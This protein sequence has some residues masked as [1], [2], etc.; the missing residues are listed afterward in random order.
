VVHRQPALDLL[1]EDRPMTRA[2]TSLAC[3]AL[4]VVGLTAGCSGDDPEATPSSPAPT[5]VAAPPP[6]PPARACYDLDFEAAA[7]PT[8][9]ARPVSCRSPHTTV[10]IHV[11]TIRPVVDGHLLAV[12]SDTAQAQVARRCRATYA[13]HVG[14]TVEARRLSRFTVVWFTPTL[15]QSDDGAL[16]FRCDLVALAGHDRL[17]QLPGRARGVLDARDALDRFG[18]C[19]TT[20]PASKRFQR[21]ICSRRHS[22]RARAT[23]AVPR[24][25][26]YLDKHAGAVADAACHDV[27]ARLAGDILKLKWSFEWPTREQWDAGQRYGI[28]WTPDPA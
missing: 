6:A 17:A 20:S 25:S 2:R 23:V 4:A 5:T 9:D 1:G 21:V 10:T 19:G 22:W 3:V 15:A 7:K 14:G 28:C 26:A 27:E 11:G 18:T 12:D 16:W 8:N 13:A 24:G